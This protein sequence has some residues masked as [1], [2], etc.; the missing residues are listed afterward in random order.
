M[1]YGGCH[2]EDGCQDGD[3]YRGATSSGWPPTS[4]TPPRT[5]S[6][7][8]TTRCCRRRPSGRSGA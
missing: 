3:G 6:R 8:T 5:T 2:P 7:T 4:R 1:Q